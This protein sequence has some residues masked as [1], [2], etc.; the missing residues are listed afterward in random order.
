MAVDN[1]G[2]FISGDKLLAILAQASG[3]KDIVTTIDASMCIED[4]GFNVKRTKVGDPFVS[5]EL[6]TFGKFGGEPS[7]AWVFPQI[8]LCPDGIYATAQ[9]VSIANHQKLSEMVDNIP[10]Y[11]VIRGNVT[12]SVSDM[13]EL[14]QILISTLNPV[15]T[16]TLDGLK[17]IFKEGWLLI[18]PSGTE[19][20]LRLTV[21]SRNMDTARVFYEKGADIVKGYIQRSN[22]SA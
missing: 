2:R 4:L 20:K 11:P 1:L 6:K 8:S 14:K 21:E 19:P 9:I 15:S 5:E 3:S 22:V 10:A 7:G 18:R 12:G 13:T 16:N 17:L